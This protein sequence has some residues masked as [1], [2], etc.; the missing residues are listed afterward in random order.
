VHF[1]VS[2]L[3]Q[4]P[5]HFAVP[6]HDVRG[7]EAKLQVPVEHDSHC[8]SHRLLQHAPSVQYPVEHSPSLAHA[9]AVFFGTQDVPLQ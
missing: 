7:T 4:E 5:A 2:V 8:P 1:F 3:S 9:P 6:P